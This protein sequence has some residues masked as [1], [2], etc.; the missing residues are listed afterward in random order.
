MHALELSGAG[1]RPLHLDG[2]AATLC[3]WI[4]SNQ[5]TLNA[6]HT[7]SLEFSWGGPQLTVKGPTAHNRLRLPADHPQG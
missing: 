4:A 7:G 2:L 6:I 5:A 3:A 1:Q